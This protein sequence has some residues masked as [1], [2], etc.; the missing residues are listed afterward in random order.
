MNYSDKMLEIK[1]YFVLLTRIIGHASAPNLAGRSSGGKRSDRRGEDA[2]ILILHGRV[3][4][5]EPQGH[6]SGRGTA[7]DNPH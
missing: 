5:Q 4:D 2:G 1:D 3:Q 7:S 6:G